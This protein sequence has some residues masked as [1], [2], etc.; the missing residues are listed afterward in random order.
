MKTGIQILALFVVLL[1]FFIAGFTSRLS[2]SAPTMSIS[3]RASHESKW[4]VYGD[5]RVLDETRTLNAAVGYIWSNLDW[6]PKHLIISFE[7]APPDGA[8]QRVLAPNVYKLY[9]A[10]KPIYALASHYE[11]GSNVVTMKLISLDIDWKARSI[12]VHELEHIRLNSMGIGWETE[13][14]RLAHEIRATRAETN[15]YELTGVP[16]TGEGL[17][18]RRANARLL[19]RY[20]TEYLTNH[21][22]ERR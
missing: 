13:C 16:S 19:E 10:Q 2:G 5:T 14:E 17:T 1:V 15:H 22:Y 21:C 11:D 20:N 9:K 6:A 18:F 3:K 4:H 12:I 8:L 7:I